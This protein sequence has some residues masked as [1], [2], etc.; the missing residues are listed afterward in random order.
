MPRG[1]ARVNRGLSKMKDQRIV[2]LTIE[3]DRLKTNIEVIAK[4][5]NA[6]IQEHREELNQYLLA[7][8][9]LMREVML[10]KIRKYGPDL[11][12][13]GMPRV[14]VKA[15]AKYV[16]KGLLHLNAE[17]LQIFSDRVVELLEAEA[18][19]TGY[20]RPDLSEFTADIEKEVIRHISEAVA[21]EIDKKVLTDITKSLPKKR[22]R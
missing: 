2:E 21:K 5:R 12:N 22:K 15:L 1:K 13:A 18:L 7:G 10:A 14:G 11:T 8:M 4:T 20:G 3:V 19:K 9:L 17:S 6:E 16:D